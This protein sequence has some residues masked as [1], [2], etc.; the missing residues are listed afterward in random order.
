M[1]LMKFYWIL[2]NA[3]V[4]ALTVSKG[5]TTGGGGVKPVPPPWVNYILKAKSTEHD[6]NFYQ[7]RGAM[8]QNILPNVLKKM[9]KKLKLKL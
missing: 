2:Q 3:R 4:T 1:P 5:K 9:Y 7:V 6:T 8:P